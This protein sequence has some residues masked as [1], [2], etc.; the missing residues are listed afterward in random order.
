MKNSTCLPAAVSSSQKLSQGFEHLLT[1]G[2]NLI[3]LSFTGVKQA[4]TRK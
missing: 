4:V 2:Y 1:F 3:N